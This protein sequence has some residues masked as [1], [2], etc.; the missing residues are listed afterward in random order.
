[1]RTKRGI[2]ERARENAWFDSRPPFGPGRVDTF[3]PYKVHAAGCPW[4]TR[5]HRRSAVDL[6][7]AAAGRGCGCTGMATTIGR[8]AEQER[9]DRRGC[10]AGFARPRVDEAH[11]E[12][13][14]GSRSRR[15]IL[16]NESTRRARMK[17]GTCAEQACASCH[18][19][20]ASE[21]GQVTPSITSGPMPSGSIRLPRRWPRA[22]NTIG[23]GKP[24]RFS[25]FRKTNG[26]A[27]M[28]LDGLW[29]RAPYLH[30]GSV[31]TCA[32]CCSRMSGR[33]VLSR[34]RRL[35]LDERRVRLE[36]SGSRGRGRSLRHLA[37][38]NSNAGH[39][40]GA[41]LSRQDRELLLEYLKTL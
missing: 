9:G 11:R 10:D 21:V 32:R 4:T 18:V 16:P 30:N 36:R 15:R 27:N 12:V 37:R 2:L 41:T 19:G 6:E 28:P 1:M 38:G 39:V 40:Y 34:I 17:A 24:W 20:R 29:L 25:H 5:G 33:R 22:M 31:P 35:R 26:Y 14:A 7:P 3:N 23:E 8:G 13:D